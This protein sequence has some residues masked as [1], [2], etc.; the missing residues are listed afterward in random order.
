MR[1]LPRSLWLSLAL[2]LYAALHILGALQYVVLAL[3][4]KVRYAVPYHVTF[5]AGLAGLAWMSLKHPKVT[6]VVLLVMCAGAI[7]ELHQLFLPFR[8]ARISDVMMDTGAGLLGACVM[9]RMHSLAVGR[10]AP[11]VACASPPPS[12]VTG[13]A[14]KKSPRKEAGLNPSQGEDLEETL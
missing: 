10:A 12:I 9:R 13:A 6:K 5:Y 3:P 1:L 11:P 8:G 2:V 14:H 4:G 7:D